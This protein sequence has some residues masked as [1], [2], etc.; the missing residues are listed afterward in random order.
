ME[1]MQHKIAFYKDSVS[2]QIFL[3]AEGGYLTL[4]EKLY[5][6]AHICEITEQYIRESDA[7]ESSNKSD[8]PLSVEME[9]MHK[10]IHGI[11][12]AGGKKLNEPLYDTPA[13][14]AAIA[15]F[16]R[17]AGQDVESEFTKAHAEELVFCHQIRKDLLDFAFWTQYEKLLGERITWDEFQL[18]DDLYVGD[19]LE[20]SAQ[21]TEQIVSFRTTLVDYRD[22]VK[23]I[24]MQP[25]LSDRIADACE[26]S[27]TV[28]SGQQ[29]T[30]EN[31]SVR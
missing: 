28:L 23:A 5:A 16:S 21:D 2:E 4:N 26:R 3:L 1:N 14:S 24:E 19:P 6:D 13:Y 20:L 18:L 27:S 17:E 8:L 11:A 9:I 15:Y 7:W 12:A 25:A 29:E 30:R 31:E 10:A 22:R